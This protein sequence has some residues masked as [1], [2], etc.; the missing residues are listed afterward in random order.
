M[1]RFLSNKNDSEIHFNNKTHDT[2]LDMNNDWKRKDENG[3]PIIDMDGVF[4]PVLSEKEQKNPKNNLYLWIDRYNGK[5]YIKF[6]ATNKTIWVR[7]SDAGTIHLQ[8]IY[9]WESE[10]W[11]KDFETLLHA[12]FKWSGN[13][14][15]SEMYSEEAYEVKNADE[16]KEFIECITYHVSTKGKELSNNLFNEFQKKHFKDKFSCRQEQ[17]DFV[18][19]FIAYYNA[20]NKTERRF[21]LYAVCR[22]GKTAS[23]LYTMIEKCALEYK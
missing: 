13:K 18:N 12:K 4:F 20:K 10:L 21:L 16:V 17:Q 14:T 11:D 2:S 5:W 3:N 7:Y 1:E 22:F 15:E 9:C 19:K 23:T 6:G 8:Q